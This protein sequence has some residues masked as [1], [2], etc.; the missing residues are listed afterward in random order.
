[1]TRGRPGR[2]ARR[3]LG[4]ALAVMIVLPVHRVLSGRQTGLAGEATVA[5]ADVG[6]AFLWTGSA[7]VIL[8]AVLAGCLLPAG[9]V[10]AAVEVLRG[11]LARA[12]PLPIALV[13]GGLALL[14]SAAFARFVLDARP[15]H[16]DAMSQ[17][18][19][20][21]FIAAGMAAG[22][23][24]VDPAF[25][26]IQNGVITPRGWVS[27]YPPGHV[28]LLALGMLA[29]TVWLIGPLMV[30]LAAFFLALLVIRLLP[31]RPATARAGALLVASSPFLVCLGASYMNHAPTLAALAAAIWFADRALEHGA[32]WSSAAGIAAGFAFSIRPLTA[33]AVAGVVLPILWA[34]RLSR[35]AR[36]SAA[37]VLGAAPFL[38]GV[39][40]YNAYFFGSPTRFGY[41]AALGPSAGLG[42]G[43]DPWGNVYG[44]VEAIGYTAADL[45]ALGVALL[46]SPASPVLLVALLLLLAPRL[47]RA[48][49]I[50]A[51]WAV[52]PVAA[53]ALYWHHGLYMGPRML[54]EAAPAW[55]LLAVIAVSRAW[56][57][58]RTFRMAGRMR[59]SLAGGAVC[60]LALAFW[61]APQRAAGHAPAPTDIT[62][63]DI[64][65]PAAPALVFVHDAWTARL[66][67][68]LAATGMR[69]DS[70]ETALRQNATCEVQALVDALTAG[71]RDGYAA[72]LAR[73]DLDP[74]A[75]RLPPRVRLT[76]GNSIRV[77]PAAV[78]TPSCIRQ[79]TAD[80]N[81]ILDLAPLV[82]RGDLPGGPV[83]GTLFVR[84]LGPEANAELIARMPERRP[85]LLH[86]PHD[87]AVPVLLPH[88]QGMVRLWHDTDVP[89]AEAH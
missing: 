23:T 74:R 13:A 78:P 11:T 4:A 62:A 31:E 45:L 50:F 41:E 83:R 12:R 22:P 68:Q 77:D 73:L 76:T 81:G 16:L 66:A 38:A 5:A 49:R 46:E 71:D 42:F 84:D 3:S 82:W 86:T 34:G 61:L 19:H 52:A 56:S 27:H 87:G 44:A 58:A 33:L 39:G 72:H 51:A 28:L 47:G 70:V 9:R 89:P 8:V 18:L 1:M 53:N 79:V 26:Q 17:L 36:Y 69:L 37:A 15:T 48:E 29:G 67:M 25:W 55:L 57:H 30:G 64:A 21:R 35:F 63:V 65:V 14:L 40:F 54:Y 24:D 85:F 59:T 32:Q 80:R 7:V 88:E 60:T 2:I 75:D 10:E 6:H 43:R 20:A